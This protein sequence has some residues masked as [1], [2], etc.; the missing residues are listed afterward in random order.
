[1]TSGSPSIFLGLGSLI[2]DGDK[3]IQRQVLAAQLA[4]LF[5]HLALLPISL[6][7]ISGLTGA[8]NLSRAHAWHRVWARGGADKVN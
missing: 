7:L 3:R 2:C 1:M 5:L 8:V 6:G 4:Q